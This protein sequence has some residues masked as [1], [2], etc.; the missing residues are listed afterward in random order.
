MAKS[1]VV[2][3]DNRPLGGTVMVQQPV[4]GTE[5][6]ARAAALAAAVSDAGQANLYLVVELPDP[7]LGNVN[8]YQEPPSQGG[9]GGQILFP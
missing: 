4:Y 5:R 8:V 3:N 9:G 6:E 2:I 7:Q 1:W